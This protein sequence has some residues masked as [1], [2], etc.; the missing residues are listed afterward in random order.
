[1]NL[2]YRYTRDYDVVVCGLGVA[3][4]TAAVQCARL[5]LKTAALDKYHMPGGV[6]TVLGNNSIDQFNNPFIKGDNL[7]ITGIGWEFVNRLAQRGGAKIPDMNAEYKNHAQYGVKVDHLAAADL[8]NEMLI[9][10]G[11]A[12]Y[13]GQG[14][15]DTLC[16][17]CKS[18]AEN[19][20]EVCGC[21]EHRVDAVVIS[22]KSGPALLRA[23]VF[24]DCTGDGD[25]CA[26]S[27]CDFYTG[28]SDLPENLFYEHV[29]GD[30][31][32]GTRAIPTVQPGT[33]FTAK[34]DKEVPCHSSDS[35]LLTL[36][37]IN[38]RHILAQKAGGEWSMLCA[39]AIAPRES[40]RIVCRSMLKAD[41][42]MS[43]KHYEDSVCYTFWF[44]DIHREGAH[45]HIEYLR[46]PNT[47]SIRLSSMTPAGVTNLLV[48]GRCIGSDRATNSAIR[49]KSSCMA[50]GQATG[51]AA[52]VSLRDKTSVPDVDVG[53]VKRILREC[54]AIVPG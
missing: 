32:S 8:M 25:I 24:I 35:D 5:G 43:G 9:K 6:L 27:G 21:V 7:V 18:G 33:L 3:G 28:D 34:F 13:L 52:F 45:A 15:V 42:Y 53:E 17:P 10:A 29:E 14:A 50:M 23:K 40:R 4:F 19:I 44:I 51:A 38:A 41:D 31:R 48:A 37:E 16:S 30:G 46:S 49:V 54:G 36:D 20:S 12:L 2:S 1:M 26:F 39:P 47:P 22:T 11:V